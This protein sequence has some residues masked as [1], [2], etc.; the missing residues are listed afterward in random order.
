MIKRGSVLEY[1]SKRF[2]VMEIIQND[3]APQVRIK[4]LTKAEDATGAEKL[5]PIHWLEKYREIT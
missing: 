3:D 1:R 5:I 2:V 4:K